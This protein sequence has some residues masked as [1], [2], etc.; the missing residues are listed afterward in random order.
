[1]GIFEKVGGFHRNNRHRMRDD[2]ESCLHFFTVRAPLSYTILLEVVLA[3][4]K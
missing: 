4:K 3:E 2:D 1:M